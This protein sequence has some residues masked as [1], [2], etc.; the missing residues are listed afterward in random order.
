MWNVFSALCR[1]ADN[2]MEVF[3]VKA[4]GKQE[5]INSAAHHCS[6]I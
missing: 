5:S 3:M 1:V 4:E 2:H 6:D